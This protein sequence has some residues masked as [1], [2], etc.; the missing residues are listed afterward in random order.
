MDREDVKMLVKKWWD[1]YNDD[2]LTSYK[3]PNVGGKFVNTPELNL[4]PKDVSVKEKRG[5]RRLF[6]GVVKVPV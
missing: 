1:I 4:V 3:K 5:L 2:S 6:T